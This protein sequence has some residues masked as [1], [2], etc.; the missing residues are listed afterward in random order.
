MTIN[1]A[2]GPAG[3]RDVVNRALAVRMG[4][5][6]A[7]ASPMGGSVGFGSPVPVYHIGLDSVTNQADPLTAARQTSWRFPVIGAGA[8]SPA[9]LVTVRETATDP[10][11][12]GLSHG[13]LAQNFLRAA[14]LA[15]QTFG[16]SP[17]VFDPRLLEVPALQYAALWLVGGGT[18]HFI[19][20]L[21][22]NPP[23]SA[24]LSV[25]NDI[26]P[27]LKARVGYRA[28]APAHGLT[29]SPTN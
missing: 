27:A 5:L 1:R 17:D 24:P 11:F 18:N 20:L 28:N 29:S 15:E 8:G 21:D 26:L 4:S 22:G 14:S 25:I 23:G 12:E 9:G 19:P 3:G 2:N 6:R 13:V 10:S 16:S 7:A